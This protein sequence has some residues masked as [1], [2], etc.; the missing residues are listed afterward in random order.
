MENR[1][2]SGK[3][4]SGNDVSQWIVGG[5]LVEKRRNSG[6]RPPSAVGPRRSCD[7]RLASRRALGRF[8]VER[9]LF[10]LR[11][12]RLLQPESRPDDRNIPGTREAG[13]SQSSRAR[14]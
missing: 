7:C 2:A 5:K 9:N 3:R 14:R 1:E 13:S 6:N 10:G 11:L 4:E 12:E 8:T